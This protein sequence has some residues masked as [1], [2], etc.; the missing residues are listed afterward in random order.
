MHGPPVMDGINLR[1]ALANVINAGRVAVDADSTPDP[2]PTAS[3]EEG[4]RD[5]KL[6]EI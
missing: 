6:F 5:D 1:G 4:R 2:S 3:R